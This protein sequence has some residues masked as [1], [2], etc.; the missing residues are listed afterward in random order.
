MNLDE[1]LEAGRGQPAAD[2]PNIAASIS[3][4]VEATKREGR[5]RIPDWLR[6][7]LVLL[8]VVPVGGLALTGGA[9][10]FDST[11]NPDV[12]VPIVYTTGT[13]QT[14][15]CTVLIEG[16]SFFHP[17]SSMIADALED[18]NWD[19]IGQAMYERALEISNALL[20]ESGG[21]AQVVET[22]RWGWYSAQAQLTILTVREPLPEGENA[23][24]DSDCT[25]Q[26]R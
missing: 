17:G 14:F 21:Q 6:R 18:R 12:V 15:Q 5:R 20:A 3:S 22:D 25:G 8:W 23:A 7:A 11:V 16:G 26:L 13:G 9:V 4:L 19:G 24:M 10:L 1:A 2:D